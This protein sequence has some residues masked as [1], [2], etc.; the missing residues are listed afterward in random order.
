M[1]SS[2]PFAASKISLFLSLTTDLH[3]PLIGT[4]LKKILSNV[5]LALAALLHVNS[6]IS[7]DLYVVTKPT[8][9]NHIAVSP[10]T[11]RAVAGYMPIRTVF[12]I[13]QFP[14]TISLAHFSISTTS[15]Q[16]TK[17]PNLQESSTFLPCYSRPPSS[18]DDDVSDKGRASFFLTQ[19]TPKCL[20]YTSLQTKISNTTLYQYCT[21]TSPIF[22]TPQLKFFHS[23]SSFVLSVLSHR[24]LLFQYFGT[25]IVKRLFPGMMFFFAESVRSTVFTL[26]E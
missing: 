26:K 8:S 13:V 17:A 12:L 3:V 22:R 23:S 16:T 11:I 1:N 20:I 21:W 4:A 19:T 24:D 7:Q 6:M 14:P 2:K 5:Q 25:K 15:F 10:S 18:L 9:K